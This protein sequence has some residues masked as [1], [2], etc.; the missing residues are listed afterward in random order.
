MSVSHNP[1]VPSTVNRLSAIARIEFAKDV[2]DV[3]FRRAD[4]N[5]QLFRD[6]AI[7]KTGCHQAQYFNLALTQRLDQR[8]LC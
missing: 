2:V 1:Q 4:T 8:R 5:D 7:R 3:G 6:S